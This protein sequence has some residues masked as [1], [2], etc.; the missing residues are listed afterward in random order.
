MSSRTLQMSVAIAFLLSLIS[1]SDAIA[2]KRQPT[3]SDT[4]ACKSDVVK[5]CRKVMSQDDATVLDCLQQHR[6]QCR[7]VLEKNGS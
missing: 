3:K 6:S 2:Q 1:A 7:T 5:Y 4:A